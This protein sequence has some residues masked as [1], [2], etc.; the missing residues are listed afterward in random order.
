MG[1]APEN[2][3]GATHIRAMQE[4]VSIKVDTYLGM[5]Q[6]SA[7]ECEGEEVIY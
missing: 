4:E 2:F 6:Y 3:L 7:E 1:V 5:L